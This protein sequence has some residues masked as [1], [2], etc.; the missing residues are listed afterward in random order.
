[1]EDFNKGDYVEHW[2][3]GIGKIIR[4]DEESIVV[5]FTRKGEVVVPQKKT[6]S[7][8]KVNPNG[9]L[10]QLY[11][12]QENIQKLIGQRSTEIIKLLIYDEEKGKEIKRSRIKSLLIKAKP[13][14]RGWRRDFGLV[15]EDRWKQWWAS[16]SKK[17]KSDSWFDTSSKKVIVL[18][19]R[20]VSEVQSVYEQF[21]TEEQAKRRLVICEKLIAASKEDE[22]QAVLRDLA[23]FLTEL[24]EADPQGE[25]LSL[26][27]LS[28]VQLNNKGIQVEALRGRE[29]DLLFQI[30][31]GKKLP[32]KKLLSIYSYLT[33]MSVLDLTDHLVLFLAADDKLAK[34]VSKQFR[35]KEG[36]TSPMNGKDCKEPLTEVQIVNINTLKAGN[37]ETLGKRLVELLEFV[38][39][40]CV[41]PFFERLLLSDGVD[42]SIGDIV[43]RIVVDHELTNTI[44]AYLNRTDLSG[45]DE[46]LFLPEFTDVLGL[47][48]A[49]F[50]FKH[51]L[52]SEK[53]AR[54]RPNVFVS[55]FRWIAT[56][57]PAC[58]DEKDRQRLI[59]HANDVL[60]KPIVGEHI[61]DLRLRVSNI[62]VDFPDLEEVTESLDVNDLVSM[63]KTR[64]L[65]LKQRLA[66]IRLLAKKGLKSECQS[67]VHDLATGVNEDDFVILEHIFKSF[68]DADLAKEL[69]KAI[70][71]EVPAQGA[72]LAK[73]LSA[74]V[75]KAGL[76]DSFGEFVL[77]D[78]EDD[79]HSQ[80]RKHVRQLLVSESVVR[81]VVDMGLRGFLLSRQ[82]SPNFLKR[83]SFY[84]SPF[85]KWTLEEMKRIYIER[86]GAVESELDEEKTRA[87]EELNTLLHQQDDALTDA[88]DKTSQRYEEYLRRLV[89]LLSEIQTIEEEILTGKEDQKTSGQKGVI[90]RL[91]VVREDIEW[92]L[93]RLEIIG[94]E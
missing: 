60:S 58:F 39:N 17:L 3:D 43:S 11:E 79:W 69:F 13:T 54:E 37:K 61:S 93:K 76:T 33:S 5:D 55:A 53:T 30:L 94:R 26:A 52:L 59:A 2:E 6:A 48:N 80:N 21:L 9:L 78:H 22:D 15:D 74:F 75:E 63:A 29:N 67:I 32:Y 36:L 92:V 12:D 24:I 49:E 70:V 44:Y 10:A 82:G 35:G 47:Q 87:A 42:R 86:L 19:E 89:P 45:D 84:C 72:A 1:M 46:I 71:N 81:R 73:P 57:P 91:A 68:P 90:D 62:T 38:G 64:L 85:M 34:A 56:K 50:A 20:P 66:A 40:K 25:F 23:K 51:I 4:V 83:L 27:V 18:R 41:E 88:V 16:V 14:E 8:K 28:A 65:P 77:F 7:L 31:L